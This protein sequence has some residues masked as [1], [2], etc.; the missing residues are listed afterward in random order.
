MAPPAQTKNSGRG[1][2]S[3]S[4]PRGSNRGGKSGGGPIRGGI[5]KAPSG[6]QIKAPKSKPGDAKWLADLHTWIDGHTARGGDRPRDKFFRD[7]LVTGGSQ[8]FLCGENTVHLPVTIKHHYN[9]FSQN[10]HMFLTIEGREFV[11]TTDHMVNRAAPGEMPYAVSRKQ[12][13]GAATAP[14]DLASHLQTLL[15]EEL[16]L[17]MLEEISSFANNGGIQ[18]FSFTKKGRILMNARREAK[19]LID[20]HHM[21]SLVLNPDYESTITIIRTD[22]TNI[23]LLDGFWD[24]RANECMR[25]GI[26][27]HYA[28]IIGKELPGSLFKEAVKESTPLPRQTWMIR[29][30]EEEDDDVGEDVEGEE[31]YCSHP[32]LTRFTSLR[33]YEIVQKAA[34]ILETQHALAISRKIFDGKTAHT[35]HVEVV[36]EEYVQFDIQLAKFDGVISPPIQLGAVYDIHLWTEAEEMER[37]DGPIEVQK[38]ESKPWKGTAI[39]IT[40]TY[41]VVMSI[42]FPRGSASPAIE[43]GAALLITL[44]E[45]INM[46]AFNRQFA[47][48]SHA[49]LLRDDSPMKQILLGKIDTD[50]PPA[51]TPLNTLVDAKV[52]PT[53]KASMDAFKKGFHLNEEQEQAFDKTFKSD[54]GMVLVQGPPGTGKTTL[55]AFMAVYAASHDIN[56]LATAPSNTA[57]KA[58]MNKVIAQLDRLDANVRKAFKVVYFPTMSTTKDD[59]QEAMDS[60]VVDDSASGDETL[61]GPFR[62]ATHI[63]QLAESKSFKGDSDAGKWL[64]IRQ[65]LRKGQSLPSKNP[66]KEYRDWVALSRVYAKEVFEDPAV[67]L[68]VCTCNNS[69]HELRYG[70]LGQFHIVDEAAFGNEPDVMTPLQGRA[71]MILLA[72]DHQQLQPIVTSPRNNEFAAQI[73]LSLFERAVE[74]PIPFVCLKVN[75]RM[76]PE[77]ATLPGALTYGGLKCHPRTQ[78]ERPVFLAWQ[79]YWHHADT[80]FDYWRRYPYFIDH[81]KTP[82]YRRLL[83]NVKGVSGSEGNG[84]SLVNFANANVVGKLVGEILGHQPSNGVAPISP[85]DITIQVPYSAQRSLIKRQIN[86]RYPQYDIR[87]KSIDNNQGGETP[88]IILDLTP[89]NSHHGSALGFLVNWNRMNVALTR[90]SDVLIMVANFDVWYQE[91]E[92]IYKRC[93][94]WAYFLQDILN[95]GDVIDLCSTWGARHELP[96]NSAELASGVWTKISPVSAPVFLNPRAQRA[97][98]NPRI[99]QFLTR[100][101]AELTEKLNNSMAETFGALRIDESAA[102]DQEMA[103]AGEQ[104]AEETSDQEMG[105]EGATQTG[106][107]GFDALDTAE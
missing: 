41:D 4:I 99:H 33:E 5:T 61:L 34:L 20:C 55:N 71:L 31:I 12:I 104:A 18:V 80:K 6:R 72:G 1:S 67:K 44:L 94:N 107:T 37:D 43:H 86:L 59:L 10:P 58:I 39:D 68:L 36:E 105:Q 16:S 32:A 29:K 84:R 25:F 47:A 90:P 30:P 65:Y 24:Q 78:V 79:S 91:I 98:E 2:G 93:H 8:N 40:P 42:S 60:I 28:Q 57:T 96:A 100:L 19:P 38:T 87:V 15:R 97:L 56:V 14:R 85:S 54:M 23:E 49:G 17:D 50:L 77:I 48:I 62:L 83:F 92:L 81:R 75:F 22:F 102:K 7:M 45:N 76:P 63:V 21:L 66:V 69:A 3:G 52:E 53:F 9:V 35:A 26:Y 51:I 73:A 103:E 89:A 11:I 101:N 46:M 88:I 74:S 70:F 27:P 64:R 106:P 13:P 82:G 95:R